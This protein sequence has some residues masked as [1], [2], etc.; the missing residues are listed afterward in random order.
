MLSVG[1]PLGP[2]RIA[3]DKCPYG[4]AG[5]TKQPTPSITLQHQKAGNDHYY[6]S[7]GAKYPIPSTHGGSHILGS[8]LLKPTASLLSS[9]PDQ[10]FV[11]P[12]TVQILRLTIPASLLWLAE[13]IE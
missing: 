12:T 9:P 7:Y 5:N 13:V 10:T 1:A 11:N 3:N 2:H 8:Y 4:G 6:A